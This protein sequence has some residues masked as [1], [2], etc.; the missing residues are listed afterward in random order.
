M[1][2]ER[3]GLG[4][5]MARTLPILSITKV[6]RPFA[7]TAAPSRLFPNSS[8]LTGK[9]ECMVRRLIASEK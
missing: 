2:I 7:K 1:V 8:L 3:S 6:P 9:T 5:S 4:V